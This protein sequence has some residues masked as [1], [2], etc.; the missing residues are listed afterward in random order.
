VLPCI[1]AA[2]LAAHDGG[3]IGILSAYTI[4]LYVAVAFV[5]SVMTGSPPPAEDSVRI[6]L[7]IA[8]QIA[9]IFGGLRVL[10]ACGCELVCQPRAAA[11]PSPA[12]LSA[13]SEPGES[14]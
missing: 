3:D 13:P 6:F 9:L 10:R 14:E 1:W 11:T 5:G 7:W 2:F 4:V 8:S 12:P